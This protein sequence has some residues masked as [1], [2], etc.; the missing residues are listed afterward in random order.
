MTDY[1]AQMHGVMPSGDSWSTGLH[2]TSN[3]SRSALLT[4]FSNAWIAAWTNGTY[5]LNT[6]YFTGTTTT[7]YSVANLNGTMQQ[8][9]KD[10]L[11]SVTPGT[12]SDTALPDQNAIV[13][14]LRSPFI[15]AYGRGR[16]YLPPP[17]E[18]IVN[19]GEYTSAAMTR[20]KTAVQS[21]FTAIQS[22]GSTIFVTNMKALKDGTPPFRK[23]VITSILV[24]RKPGS[25][26]RRAERELPNYV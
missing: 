14:S 16:I 24:S 21:V 13:V 17:V 18:G 20:V 10:R 3:Q 7:S 5:G 6:L 12:S 26:D 1:Y 25:Q 8:V 9:Q 22:D 4:T 2:I 23:T 15:Q 11:T 19:A